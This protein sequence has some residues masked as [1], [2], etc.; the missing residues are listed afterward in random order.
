M[1]QAP[2]DRNHTVVMSHD[3]AIAAAAAV[4]VDASV[5][6]PGSSNVDASR[7]QMRVNASGGLVT[8]PISYNSEDEA[9]GMIEQI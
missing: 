3:D 5:T 4:V 6:F 1:P 8:D 7:A 9:H 2:P